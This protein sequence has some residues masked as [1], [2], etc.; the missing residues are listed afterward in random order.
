[1][2][3][4]KIKFTKLHNFCRDLVFFVFILCSS[5]TD[6]NDSLQFR[7]FFNDHNSRLL[8]ISFQK[9]SDSCWKILMEIKYFEMIIVNRFV[10]D[11][12]DFRVSSKRD[13]IDFHIFFSCTRQSQFALINFIHYWWH[14]PALLRANKVMTVDSKCAESCETVEVKW[15]VNGTF[16]GKEIYIDLWITPCCTR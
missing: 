14:C 15:M 3:N 16:K 5:T 6:D 11:F 10:R 12:Q 2:K 7:K 8:E 9:V 4:K 1:M 13:R